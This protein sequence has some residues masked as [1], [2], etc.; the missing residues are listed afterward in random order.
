MVLINCTNPSSSKQPVVYNILGRTPV[1]GYI[2]IC[3][4]GSKQFQAYALAHADD[5]ED[6]PPVESCAIK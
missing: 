6:W 4:D 5:I 1:V 2:L 3:S